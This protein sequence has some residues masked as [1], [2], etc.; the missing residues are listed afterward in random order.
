MLRT[1]TVRNVT[2]SL[3]LWWCLLHHPVIHKRSSYQLLYNSLITPATGGILSRLTVTLGVIISVSHTTWARSRDMHYTGKVK[4]GVCLYPDNGRR[5]VRIHVRKEIR[6][7]ELTETCLRRCS[8]T[9]PI[10]PWC[11]IVCI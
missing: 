10:R 11:F 5:R 7:C 2:P 9:Y 4:A 6:L 8:I 3:P 1:F